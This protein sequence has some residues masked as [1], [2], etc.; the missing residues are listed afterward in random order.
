MACQPPQVA[1]VVVKKALHATMMGQDA[2]SCV[3]NRSVQRLMRRQEGCST[4][5]V[6]RSGRVG[7]AAVACRGGN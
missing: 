7:S 2:S 6:Q 1:D 4:P 5:A 3:R